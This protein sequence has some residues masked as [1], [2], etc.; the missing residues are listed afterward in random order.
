[1]H[2]G[3]VV[4]GAVVDDDQLPVGERLGQHRVQGAGEEPAVVVG[5]DDHADGGAHDRAASLWRAK[6]VGAREIQ[7]RY[8]PEGSGGIRST[9]SH[10]NPTPAP[11]RSRTSSPRRSRL[12]G[13]KSEPRTMRKRKWRTVSWTI[14]SWAR[15]GTWR[16][17][18]SVSEIPE[19]S[20]PS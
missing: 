13:P 16:A 18:F 14:W 20:S 7:K 4:G 3:R 8:L 11:N 19:I 5:G 12:A 6:G 10:A 1:D 15:P 9:Y 17:K 2:L